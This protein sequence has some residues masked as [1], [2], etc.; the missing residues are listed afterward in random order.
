M[1][2]PD[3]YSALNSLVYSIFRARWG[4]AFVTQGKVRP[5]NFP[6]TITDAAAENPTLR[7]M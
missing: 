6:C 2:H 5:V 1:N 3:C 4:C 7:I